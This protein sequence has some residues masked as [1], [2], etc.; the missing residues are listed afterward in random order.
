MRRREIPPTMARL[1]SF[2]MGKTALSA[3]AVLCRVVFGRGSAVR[4]EQKRLEIERVKE[5]V[6][7]TSTR[8]ERTRVC[9]RVRCVVGKRVLTILQRTTKVCAV[10]LECGGDLQVQSKVVVWREGEQARRKFAVRVRR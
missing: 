3:L 2:W 1:T 10:S 5:A 6:G 8:D 9:K 7:H 4:R